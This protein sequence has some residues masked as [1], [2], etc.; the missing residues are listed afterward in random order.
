MSSRRGPVI[1]AAL[2]ALAVVLFA[3]LHKSGDSSTVTTGTT[4]IEVK[5]GAV[6]GGIR[7]ITV[8]KGDPVRL[9]VTSD[10][11]NQV[12]IHGYEIEKRGKPGQTVNVTFP[13]TIDGEF[14]IEDH[15]L[16]GGEE[17]SAVQIANLTV[18]P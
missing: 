12:H 10:F 7:D 17:T 11:H 13:A 4:R 16:V 9:A 8:N 1:A 2:L 5:N 15:H 6:V 18:N 3:V 14:E